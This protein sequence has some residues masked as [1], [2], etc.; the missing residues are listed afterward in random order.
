MNVDVNL[1]IQD[2]M[3]QIAQLSREKAILTALVKQYEKELDELK[4]EKKE[5]SAT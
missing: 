4:K 1:V 3:N 2:L 5:S